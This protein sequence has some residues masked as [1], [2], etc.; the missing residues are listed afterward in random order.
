MRLF[1]PVVEQAA[2]DSGNPGTVQIQGLL[3]FLQTIV[4]QEP[5]APGKRQQFFFFSGQAVGLAFLD[6]L[7]PVLNGAQKPVGLAQLLAILFT[8]QLC[9]CQ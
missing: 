2:K 6:N 4:P 8:D 5:A 9:L 1:I 7:N 3:E